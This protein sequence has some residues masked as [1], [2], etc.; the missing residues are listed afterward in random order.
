[1]KRSSGAVIQEEG[2]IRGC[3]PQLLRHKDYRGICD[4]INYWSPYAGIKTE[5]DFCFFEQ[6]NYR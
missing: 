5:V 3:S 2:S 4:E 6:E 1:M